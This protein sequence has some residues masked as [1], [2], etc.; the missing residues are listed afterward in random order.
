MDEAKPPKTYIEWI[1]CFDAID[2]DENCDII[3]QLVERGELEWTSGV[4][5]RFTNRLCDLIDRKLKK[6]ADRLQLNLNR[7]CG[8]EFAE[9]QA[10]LEMRRNYL[11]L[12]RLASLPVLPETIR[13]SI[14]EMVSNAVKTMQESLEESAKRDR[15]GHLAQLIRNVPLIPGE[16][17]GAYMSS[18][19]LPERQKLTRRVIG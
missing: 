1:Q 17:I 12:Y 18:E 11:R 4:A 14:Q 6:A 9:I 19:Q 13:L 7:S 8:N 5:E 2:K 16:Q 3:F 10:L 15:S